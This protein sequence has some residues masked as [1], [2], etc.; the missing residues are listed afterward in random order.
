MS[1][2]LAQLT[3]E[4]DQAIGRRVASPYVSTLSKRYI[5]GAIG[6]NPKISHLEIKWGNVN[7]AVCLQFQNFTYAGEDLLYDLAVDLAEVAKAG[8]GGF[9]GASPPKFKDN[10]PYIFSNPFT[11]MMVFANI[12]IK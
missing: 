2:R 3:T 6:S 12:A 5:L 7:G 8:A 4:I 1:K 9:T 11:G 10:V